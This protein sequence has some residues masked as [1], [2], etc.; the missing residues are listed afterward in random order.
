MRHFID[1]YYPQYFIHLF[2][3][4]SLFY[5]LSHNLVERKYRTKTHMKTFER[6]ILTYPKHSSHSLLRIYSPILNSEKRKII[7]HYRNSIPC[8][9]LPIKCYLPSVPKNDNKSYFKYFKLVKCARC[10]DRSCFG[11]F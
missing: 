3:D 1:I 5:P 7:G 8:F 11:F 9:C 6:I 10:Y 4:S 2:N